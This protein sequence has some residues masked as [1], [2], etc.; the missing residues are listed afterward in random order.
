M[1]HKRFLLLQV[2]AEREALHA[3]EMAA[4]AAASSGW[5]IPFKLSLTLA[6]P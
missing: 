6:H 5:C 4:A 1:T 2:A 3:E